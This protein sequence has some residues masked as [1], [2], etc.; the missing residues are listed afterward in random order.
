MLERSSFRVWPAAAAVTAALLCVTTARAAPVVDD[1]FESMS[2]VNLGPL[3]VNGALTVTLGT[4]G[5]GQLSANGAVSSTIP[6]RTNAGE[7]ITF[8]HDSTTYTGASSGGQTIFELELFDDGSFT[9]RFFMWDAIS[10]DSTSGLLSQI[11]IG[12]GVTVADDNGLTTDATIY[13][14]IEDGP[15]IDAPVPEPASAMLLAMGASL[16]C[17]RGRRPGD[18]GRPHLHRDVQQ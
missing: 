10:H 14:T 16:L 15:D 5:P 1:S 3:L 7:P 8:T 13:V 18:R 6:L 17:L 9:Y 4:A 11:D 12:L 2:E